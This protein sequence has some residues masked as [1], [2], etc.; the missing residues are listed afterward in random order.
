MEKATVIA[1]LEKYWQA[2]TTIAEEQALAAYFRG[3]AV[4][5]ELLPYRELFVYFHEEAQ[6]SAGPGFGDRILQRLGLPLEEEQAPVVPIAREPF[7]RG[8]AA[9]AAAIILIVAGLFLQK[10]ARQ[11]TILAASHAR[12]TDTYEDP[13]K[14]LAAVRR[15]LLVASKNL[16][17]GRRQLAGDR[18]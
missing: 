13:E 15:A 1:L 7:Q 6:V 11:P 9:A 8:I 2:E 17:E 16:N 18:K 4:E 5:D 3:D 12:A 10:P 14:A